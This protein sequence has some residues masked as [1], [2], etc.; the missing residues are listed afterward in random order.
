MADIIGFGPIQD[1]NVSKYTAYKNWSFTS[2]SFTQGGYN[3][4]RGIYPG[5]AIIAISSSTAVGELQ[6]WDGTYMKN[7]YY[8]INH[9][10][11]NFYSKFGYVNYE[12]GG[13]ER[14]LNHDLLV[15]SVPRIKTGDQIRLSS[16]NL[17]II[18]SLNEIITLQDNGNYELIDTRI[19]TSSFV[20]SPIIYLGF[21][22][23]FNLNRPA[24]Q[25][26]EYNVTYIP[27]ISSSNYTHGYQ[28]SFNGSSSAMIINNPVDDW[29]NTFDGDF[30]ISFWATP[31][32]PSGAP[33]DQT[34]ISK[35]WIDNTSNST[36]LSAYPFHINYNSAGQTFECFRSDGINTISLNIDLM[37][38]TQAHIVLQKTGSNIEGYLNGSLFTSTA[39]IVTG[40][41]SNHSNIYVGCTS[42]NALSIANPFNGYLDEMRIFDKA[43]TTA[44]IT[45]LS[46]L[47]D[48]NYLALQTN[49]V[50]NV[51]YEQGIMVYSP[52]QNELISG[53]YGSKDFNLAY[54]SSLDIEQYKYYI[55]VPMDQY[56]TSTNPSLYDI[57]GSLN[58]FASGSDFHPYIT[59]IGL[60]DMNYQLVAVAKLAAPIPKRNDID[61]NLEVRFDRS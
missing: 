41:V 16:I 4:L 44:E 26:S 51:F 48:T 1:S 8:G 18:G 17:T 9:L 57:T 15:Y 35:K 54:R 38:D 43:L 46:T 58:S 34:V 33:A 31:I 55:N 39:D 36:L 56:N 6:N 52:Y 30:A 40:K 14:K 53:S 29:F 7:I 13:F 32:T 21:N 45:S 49:K 28:A 25:Y 10:Y 23:G 37:L 2:Q 42:K 3:V 12:M 24:N 50:G 5:N 60:Y 22:D 59:T 19:N 47:T 20:S 11:Y 27:G 61:L